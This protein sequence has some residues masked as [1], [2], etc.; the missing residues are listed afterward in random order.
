MKKPR[1]E[2]P[3]LHRFPRPGQ[4]PSR[5]RWP[6]P[7][8]TSTWA[9]ACA[10][11]SWI[12]DAFCPW[13]SFVVIPAEGLPTAFTFVID[14]ARVADDSWLDEDHVL[15]FAPM[16]GQDQIEL[17]ADFIKDELEGKTGPRRHRKRHVQLSARGRPDPLSSSS[18][19]RDALRRRQARQCPRPH[20]PAVADQGR[21]HDQ[22]LPRGLPDRRRRAQGG[23]E[24]PRE[25]RLEGHDRDRD[26]R[27]RGPC[28]AQGGQR[29]GMVVHRRQRDRQRL[30]HRACRRGLHAAS[31]RELR[32]RGA[33]DG[34]H[35]RHVQARPGRPLA[36]LPHR[37]RPP[38]GSAGTRRISS[39][40]WP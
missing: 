37:P 25:R 32:S 9:R 22:P 12:L 35:P 1:P 10:P 36:Q 29:V 38:T 27:D 39:T 6:G 4:G 18:S 23:L 19:F 16:G 24:R 17:I 31:R 28:H 3:L 2:R 33:A 26:R 34:G 7:R 5:R 13:R 11:L 15:G 8:S 30:P 20:R 14:A 40:S 21:G